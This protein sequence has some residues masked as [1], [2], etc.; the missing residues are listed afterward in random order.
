MKKTIF[1]I[2]FS[3]VFVAIQAQQTKD[4]SKTTA[5]EKELPTTNQVIL[6]PVAAIP[7]HQQTTSIKK[8]AISNGAENTNTSQSVVLEPVQAVPLSQYNPS[9]SRKEAQISTTTKTETT[10]N[11]IVVM[12]A[13]RAIPYDEKATPK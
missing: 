7:V 4:V 5:P 8:E 1:T 10:P 3:F 11:K 6:T 12:P 9:N 13:V 2:F